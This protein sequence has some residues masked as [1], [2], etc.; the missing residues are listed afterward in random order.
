VTTTARE[1]NAERQ[2]QWQLQQQ[3]QQARGAART[4]PRATLSVQGDADVAIRIAS[5]RATKR[6]RAGRRGVAAARG[7]AQRCVSGQ[8]EAIT[9]LFA[10]GVVDPAREADGCGFIVQAGQLPPVENTSAPRV[11]RTRAP[12]VV[13]RAEGFHAMAR[14]GI[15]AR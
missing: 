2:P 13:R 14:R 1:A 6:V 5:D 12:A 8:V 10:F 9:T 7:R 3:R 15:T 11:V 4:S